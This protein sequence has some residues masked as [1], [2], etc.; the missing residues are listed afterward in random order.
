MNKKARTQVTKRAKKPKTEM[1]AIA[2]WGKDELSLP[3]CTLPL[4]LPVG[5]E[6]ELGSPAA[7]DEVEDMVERIESA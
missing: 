5:E 2:Q 4:G 3:F 7:V 1:T 6:L